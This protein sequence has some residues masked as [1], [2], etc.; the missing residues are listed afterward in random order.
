[1]SVRGEAVIRGVVVNSEERPGLLGIICE[2]KLPDLAARRGY[3]QSELIRQSQI[4]LR[5][6]KGG[7]G[8]IEETYEYVG[9]GAVKGEVYHIHAY[10][11][12]P[13]V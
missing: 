2:S 5:V 12:Y 8:Y 13:I 4:Q 9:S 3:E 10:V 7:R 6:S 11:N 1:M